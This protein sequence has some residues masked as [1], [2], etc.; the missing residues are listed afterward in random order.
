MLKGRDA[1]LCSRYFTRLKKLGVTVGQPKTGQYYR[2]SWDGMYGTVPV[3]IS[4]AQYDTAPGCLTVTRDGALH[5]M[6]ML[7][8]MHGVQYERWTG[9]TI[10]VNTNFLT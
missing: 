1:A 2:H 3:I 7:D 5:W 4:Y 6:I 9:G 8:M 10:R